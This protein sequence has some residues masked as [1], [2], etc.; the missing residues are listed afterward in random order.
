[1]DESTKRIYPKMDEEWNKLRE[2]YSNDKNLGEV[3]HPLVKKNNKYLIPFGIF[4]FGI[5]LWLSE[6]AYFGWNALPKS[7]PEI[8]CDVVSGIII[9]VGYIK[10]IQIFNK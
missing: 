3:Q 10:L 7:T 9:L 8:I 6:S 5:I 2:K 1:M 4:M